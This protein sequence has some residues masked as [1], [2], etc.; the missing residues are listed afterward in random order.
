MGAHVGANI[1]IYECNDMF[2]NLEGNLWE[3]I[4]T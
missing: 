3:D 2:L 1:Q 4:G